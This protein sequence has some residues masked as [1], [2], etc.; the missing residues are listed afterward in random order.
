MKTTLHCGKAVAAQAISP[1]SVSDKPRFPC[2]ERISPTAM[3]AF[4]RGSGE[5]SRFR[6]HNRPS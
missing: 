1:F 3:A 4:W 5:H 6:R 2:A